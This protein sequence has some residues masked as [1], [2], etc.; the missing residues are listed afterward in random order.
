MSFAEQTVLG[1]T[2]LRVS[3][4]GLGSGYG[5]PED[6]CY[7][8]FDAGVNYFYAGSVRGRG[9]TRAIRHLARRHRE[10][11][12]VVLQSY[13]SFASWIERSVE[14]GLR[15]LQIDSADIL[16]L[17][18]YDELPSPA[19]MER[20]ERMR[21]AGRFRFLGISSHKRLFLRELLG[22]PSW[23]LVHVRYN[24]AHR[25]AET[26]VFDAVPDSGAPGIVSFT[27]TRWGDLLKPRN[28][29]AGETPPPAV[30]CYRFVLSNPHVHV[31]LC[32]PKNRRE[33][34]DNLQV[35]SRGPMDAEELA[36]MRR[37]GDHV[38]G[39]RSMMSTFS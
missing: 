33:L 1:R 37:I 22:Q 2:G 28:M 12:V 8:A 11:M 39:I 4:L 10:S 35:L 9:M 29:P 20:V 18:W 24:A 31:A 32:G 19:V 6:A 25:G 7:E 38:H 15:K 23:D 13:G 5:V 21:Q 14:L 3:R 17:G 16:L 34:H 30:D 27:N 36:R 26:E